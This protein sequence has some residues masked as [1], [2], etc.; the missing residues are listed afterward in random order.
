LTGW[1]GHWE[2]VKRFRSPLLIYDYLDDLGVS[3]RGEE[4]DYEKFDLHR[5][6][7]TRA[8]VVLATARRLRD[9][10][11]RMRPDVLFCPNGADYA[12]FHLDSPPTVPDDIADVVR[13]GRPIVGYYGA[14]ARWFD[15]D[16]VRRAAERLPD[17]EFV[18]I[19]SNM[20]GTILRQSHFWRPN[21]RWLGEKSYET[22]PAY[23]HHFTV[24][25]IPFCINEITKA[26]SP[27]KLYE[28]M[29]GGRPIVTTDLP[30]CHPYE[31][32]RIARDADD[33]AAKIEETVAWGFQ[34]S[35]RHA[36]DREAR[37]NTWAARAK[38]I[39][40]GVEAKASARR[41]GQ[42][43]MH[44]VPAWHCK[45]KMEV[46]TEENTLESKKGDELENHG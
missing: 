7:A 14:L 18:L 28:Y 8:D 3:S 27:V 34:E 6:L 41:A 9:E 11:T 10:M 45:L 33:F 38:Q 2:T 13:A 17:F 22:L 4:V 42:T 20:D 5:K 35:Y 39:L 16:L 40:D 37:E 43:L 29:S 15:F 46:W 44:A 32:V 19:G 12:H 36:L 25:T 21:I 1:T 26:T 30:E 24:A 23:L 31:S